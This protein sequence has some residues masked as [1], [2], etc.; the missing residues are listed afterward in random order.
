MRYLYPFVIAFS[1][2]FLLAGCSTTSRYVTAELWHD[3]DTV[4]VAYTEY[5]HTNYIV[6]SSGKSSA[7]VIVCQAADDNSLDC[8]NQVAIDRLLNPDEEYPD[9]PPPPAEE[10]VDEPAEDAPAEEAPTE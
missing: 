9:A 5:T 4:M 10:P 8:Q 7:H 3:D 2:M 6:A 1:G